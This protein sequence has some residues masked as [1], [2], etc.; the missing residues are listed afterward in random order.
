MMFFGYGFFGSEEAGFPVNTEGLW[1]ESK[2][3]S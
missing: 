1:L 2:A 3:P